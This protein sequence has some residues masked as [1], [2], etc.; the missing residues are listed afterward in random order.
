MRMSNI[1]W[2]DPLHQ[3]HDSGTK[4][5]ALLSLKASITQP[6]PHPA[7]CVAGAGTEGPI[8]DNAAWQTASISSGGSSE[9]VSPLWRWQR[10]CHI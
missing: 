7:F 8:W 5:V 4:L 10:S 6:D 3:E 2:T 9:E 1:Q